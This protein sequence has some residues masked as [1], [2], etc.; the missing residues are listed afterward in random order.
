MVNRNS[1]G[2]YPVVGH[3]DIRQWLWRDDIPTL[4]KGEFSFLAY[5][6][7]RSYGDSCLNDG[8]ILIDTSQLNKFISFDSKNGILHC[9]AGVS[10]ASILKEF[11]PRGWFLPVTPGT[12]YVTVGGAIANDVHGKNHH[13]K[14]TFGSHVYKFTLIRSDGTIST[15]SPTEN[16]ELFSATIGGMGLTGLIADVQFQ[17]V[18]I[19]G[20]Y[21]ENES[22]RFTNVDDFFT[23]SDESDENYEFTVAWIDCLATGKNL[24]RGHFYRANHSQ[25]RKKEKESK[26]LLS[27]PFFAPEFVLNPLSIQ[28]FNTLYYNKQLKKFKAQTVHYEPYF[29]PLDIIH[30]WNKL[31]GKRGFMQYQLIVPPEHGKNAIKEILARVAASGSASFLAV[32]KKFGNKYSPG[33]MSFPREGYTLTLDFAVRGNET[34]KLLKSLDDV[35]L[36]SGGALYPAKDAR[37]SPEIFRKGFPQWERFSQSIDPKF[38]STFWRRVMEKN[39]E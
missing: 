31:Y 29:Y 22:I 18:P 33:M 32:L 21:F 34:L 5:G 7:G 15:C 17:L 38:S 35:V 23:I 9:E 20:P 3:K 39:N 14:G 28:I 37:M 26:P 10:L 2:N 30:D 36:K 24:G 8:N 13:K 6:L 4:N 25:K 16:S 19:V 1:W 12:K 11:V 27:I